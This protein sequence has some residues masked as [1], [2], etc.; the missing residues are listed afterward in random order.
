[1]PAAASELAWGRD[2]RRVTP[3]EPDTARLPET[4]S[5][6]HRDP[7][8]ASR[9]PRM[10]DRTAHRCGKH[11]AATVTSPCGSPTSPVGLAPANAVAHRRHRRDYAR[12]SSTSRLAWSAP[13][14]R[15][16]VGS[17]LVTGIFS[18]TTADRPDRDAEPILPDAAAN[19][20]D[21]RQSSFLPASGSELRPVPGML[22]GFPYPPPQPKLE[23]HRPAKDQAQCRR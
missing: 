1:M 7:H 4:F 14:R 6:R 16:G 11:M 9:A 18:A 17:T 12:L 2:R 21:R 3:Q 5:A 23:Q 10:A 22:M 13:I 20:G 15:V 8:R 19:F